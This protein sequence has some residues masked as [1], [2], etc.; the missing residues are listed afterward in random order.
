MNINNGL[1]NLNKDNIHSTQKL[2]MKK[3]TIGLICFLFASQTVYSQTY[4]A[5]PSKNDII[6]DMDYARF[7]SNGEDILLE[8]YYSFYRNQLK[9]TDQGSQKIAGFTV[10][11]KIFQADSLIDHR[12]WSG[13]NAILDS[14]QLAQNKMLLTVTKFSL[15]PGNYRLLSKITDNSS[16]NEG[17]KEIE[18]DLDSF[19]GN[20]L[21][22]SDIELATAI[23]KDSTSDF[24]DKSYYRVIPN[25]TGVYGPRN[26]MLY[27]YAETYNLDKQI[28]SA[29][30]IE[31]RILKN[32]ET[33]F[34]TY[35]PRTRRKPWASTEVGGLNVIA[36]PTGTY[37]LEL[38]L[39]D[40]ENRALFTRNKKFHVL[41][42]KKKLASKRKVTEA[43]KLLKA[44]QTISSNEIDE[45]FQSAR[46]L[47]AKDEK[48]LFRSLHL[49]GKRKFMAQ[50]WG[51]RSI[52]LRDTHLRRLKYANDHFSGRKKGWK[53]DRGRVTM[54]YGEADEVDKNYSL[55]GKKAYEIWRYYTQEG[56][57]FFIF[58]DKGAID[59]D[60]ELVHSNARTGISDPDWQRWIN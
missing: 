33:E 34:R 42:D 44:Y 36:I 29:Y 38:K 12:N 25:P 22:I 46:Y 14:T 39:I 11:A 13:Q 21:S 10:D 1:F 3:N 60:L 19:S 17:S 48:R 58:V 45:E 35:P 9:F 37:F 55:G 5:S 56:G 41:K 20:G 26:P 40:S 51:K 31:Y 28:D 6:F 18:I 54:R 24:A 47:A 52:A 53:T 15:R 27:F 43:G 49:Q 30:T 16:E 2:H 8:V 32:D 59:D 23:V 4:I 57:L 7:K 50:F